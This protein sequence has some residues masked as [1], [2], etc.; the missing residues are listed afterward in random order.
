MF[1]KTFERVIGRR[2]D[3]RDRETIAL[4][5]DIYGLMQADRD[6][7]I[8]DTGVP[9]ELANKR[10]SINFASGKYSKNWFG[11][12]LS[13]SALAVLTRLVR[14]GV[15][16]DARGLVLSDFPGG[17][18]KKAS[19]Y[20]VN[21]M[22]LDADG[23][24]TRDLIKPSN[25]VIAYATASDGKCEERLSRDAYAAGAL[26]HKLAP[27][28]TAASVLALKAAE[29]PGSERSYN[30]MCISLDGDD[31]VLRFAPQ[32]RTRYVVVF[33]RPVEGDVL[34]ALI[35]APDGFKKFGHALEREV[36][37]VG[38]TD[39]SCF[40]PVRI[41]YLPTTTASEEPADYYHALLGPPVLYDPVPLAVRIVAENPVKQRKVYHAEIRENEAIPERLRGSLEGVLLAT[42]IAEGYPE[43]VRNEN[44][45]EPLVLHRCPLADYHASNTGAAD[46]SAYVYDA[47]EH[48]RY[49]VMRCHHTSCSDRR[50]EDFVAAMIEAGDLDPS[51][52]YEEAN[53]RL[54]YADE[55]AEAIYAE[56]LAKL[57][58]LAAATMRVS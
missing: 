3:Q 9:L 36:L 8:G 54:R 50:T 46:G 45:C 49:P 42:L 22:M 34:Q 12:E 17:E 53:N 20:R 33:E 21:G 35:A 58:K 23:Y 56:K 24:P 15:D 57:A 30:N 19:V 11:A 55:Q 48:C 44:N 25:Y 47:S 1:S 26:K 16:K 52:V 4:G 40:E 51:H 18:R 29:K 31:I 10:V 13:L 43:L 2:P 39:V 14:T 38:G 41:G 5:S 37:G 32:Q 27:V 7:L 28:P 6:G